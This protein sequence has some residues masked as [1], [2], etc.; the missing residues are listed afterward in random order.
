LKSYLNL[1]L[2]LLF[3]IN[4][5]NINNMQTSGPFSLHTK[6]LRRLLI[7]Q[8]PQSIVYSVSLS[9]TNNKLP[10]TFYENR[11]GFSNN[12]LNASQF[13]NNTLDKRNAKYTSTGNVL[14][15]NS[16][17]YQ[18]IRGF[19]TKRQLKAGE[20]ESFV[21]KLRGNYLNINDPLGIFQSSST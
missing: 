8:Q 1:C 4:K 10:S 6:S 14:F 21:D 17:A 16:T 5:K 12:D 15:L 2:N 11:Y 18:Q 20:E 13:N 19:K 7:L 3:K 9:T